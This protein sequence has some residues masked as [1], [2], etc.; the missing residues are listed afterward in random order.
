MAGS[1]ESFYGKFKI[2]IADDQSKAAYSD[3][4]ALQHSNIFIV[5]NVGNI[6]DMKKL[7]ELEKFDVVI[8]NFSFKN[9]RGLSEIQNAKRKSCNNRL[10]FLVINSYNENGNKETAYQNN[11]DLYIA[12]PITSANL[13]QEIKNLAKYEYRKAERVKCHIKFIATY[14]NEK[15][16][17]F[18]TDIS[19]DGTHLLDE[20][21][22]INPEVG[23]EIEMEF[24]IPK[25]SE[26]FKCFGKIVRLTKT[27]F[28]LQFKNLTDQDIITLKYGIF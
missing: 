3:Y 13:I 15:F 1:E 7:L 2:L 16:E 22:K 21:K 12:R 23:H 26:T 28:G 24:I 4:L 6:D 20:D 25:T 9:N 14:N 8:M 19:V 5:S 27:G 18:A 17:T 10:R 11:A